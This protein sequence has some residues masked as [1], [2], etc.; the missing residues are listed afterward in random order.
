[1]FTKIAIV[2]M[3]L[4]LTTCNGEY[5]GFCETER[6]QPEAPVVFGGLFDIHN[7]GK[8]S[9]SLTLLLHNTSEMRHQ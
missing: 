7:S 8:H 9:I 4:A 2:W 3:S 6:G 1:M 5:F